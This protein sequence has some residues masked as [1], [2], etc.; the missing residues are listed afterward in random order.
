MYVGTMFILDSSY[1]YDSVRN[2]SDNKRIINNVTP[3]ISM[4]LNVWSSEPWS[5][6]YWMDD[7]IHEYWWFQNTT[8][9][10]PFIFLYIL[11]V[12]K[13]IHPIKLLL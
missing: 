9:F 13:I 11:F 3:H 2:N 1:L 10:I 4:I 8:H 5:W 7:N 6:V 12:I